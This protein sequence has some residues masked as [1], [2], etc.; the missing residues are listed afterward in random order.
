M[1]EGDLYSGRRCI[2][3]NVKRRRRETLLSHSTHPGYLVEGGVTSRT[4]RFRHCTEPLVVGRPYVDGNFG[5]PAP[6]TLRNQQ[7][8]WVFSWNAFGVQP[9]ALLAEGQEADN[10]QRI[11]TLLERALEPL[12][13]R[14]APRPRE[15]IAQLSDVGHD[16]GIPRVERVGRGLREKRDA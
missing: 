11:V 12:V 2:S 6:N 7:W 15:L 4:R 3:E 14:I 8:A 13:R 16:F 1:Q 9:D 5:R 10:S